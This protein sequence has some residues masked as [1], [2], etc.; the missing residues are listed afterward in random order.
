[1]A[2]LTDATS[3]ASVAGVDV[4]LEVVTTLSRRSVIRTTTAGFSRRSRRGWPV[5]ST[6][7]RRASR[8]RTIWRARF[9]VRPAPTGSTRRGRGKPTRTGRT[10]TPSTWCASSPAKSRHNERLRCDHHRPRRAASAGRIPVPI[11]GSIFLK[12][13]ASCRGISTQSPPALKLRGPKSRP[14]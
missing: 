6:P 8:R 9:D 10:G 1:M 7:G 5:A 3:D 11:R 4:K 2:N 12:G 14:R 13:A